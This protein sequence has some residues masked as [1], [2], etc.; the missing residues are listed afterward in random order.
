M[1]SAFSALPPDPQGYT[2]CGQT[3]GQASK[4]RLAEDWGG[5]GAISVLP[6]GRT[7]VSIQQARTFCYQQHAAACC[8]GLENVRAGF[9][10]SVRDLGTAYMRQ[11][12][13]QI[14]IP[15]VRGQ[16]MH[17]ISF[18]EQD[19]SVHRSAKIITRWLSPG[20]S[21]PSEQPEPSVQLVRWV[22]A[23]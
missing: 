10:N 1:P 16:H 12:L 14:G 19:C 18:H 8:A 11:Q 6:P 3:D 5:T 22:L 20:H 21:R 7:C 13:A 17:W 23:P 15:R 4:H 2:N 9:S